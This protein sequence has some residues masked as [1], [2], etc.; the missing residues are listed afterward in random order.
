[1]EKRGTT[2][3]AL[4]ELVDI[5]P[6]LSELAGLPLPDHVQGDSFAPLLSN[7]AQPW[8]QAVFSQFP[9][10]AQETYEGSWEDKVY[11]GYSMRTDRYRYNQ[12]IEWNTK[13]PV[14]REL[15][16]H[17]SDAEE[18]VNIIDDP[19]Y[20]AVADSLDR[21]FKQKLKE[22]HRQ[23]KNRQPLTAKQT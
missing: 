3:S 2:S 6:T 1:M 5:Y 14:A 7:P 23:G 13:E 8:K 21:V 15:Y 9:R 12:W 17:Q 10:G 22:A 19:A 18:T 4:V 16:D 11:I 20:Q